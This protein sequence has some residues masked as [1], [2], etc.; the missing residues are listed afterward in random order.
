M[1][2]LCFAL[3]HC[4]YGRYAEPNPPV[5]PP[6]VY[7]FEPGD[8]ATQSIIDKIFAENGGTNPTWNGQFSD[9]R[10][11][12]LFKPGQ[13]G[14]DVNVGYYT[15]VIGL[16]LRPTDVSIPNVMAS[17]GDSNY[18]GGALDNF[19]RSAEN[20]VTT[21]TKTQ[22]GKNNTM[23]WAVSQGVSL[24]RIIVNGNLDL[25]EGQGYASGGYMSNSYVFGTIDSGSQQQWYTRNAYMQSW[26]GAHWNFLYQGDSFVNAPNSVC[27]NKTSLSMVIDSTPV[28]AEKPFIT[29]DWGA[30]RYF[31]AI[32][33]IEFN[34]VGP[35]DY[36]ASLNKIPRV[37]F[38]NVYVTNPATD[39]AAS[40]NAKIASGLHIIFTPGNYNLTEAIQVTQSNVCLV[41]IGYPTLMPMNGNPAI[42][43]SDGVVGVRISSVLLQAGP[44]NSSTLLQFGST[45]GGSSNGYNFLY[46]IFGRVGGP[47]DPNV[48]QY[49]TDTMVQ[50]N[51]DNVVM[52]N[53]WL[54]RADHDITGGYVYSGDNPVRTALQVYG[55]NVVLYALK[56]EHTLGNI[57][58]WYGNNGTCF[59]FQSEFPYDVTQ[60]EYGDPGFNAFRVDES[61]TLFQGYSLGMYSFFRDYAVTVENAMKAPLNVA[62]VNVSHAFT[63]WLNGQG[64]ISHVI[65]D[66][67]VAVNSQF[68]DTPSAVCK[69]NQ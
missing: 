56:A 53:S 4:V 25:Y 63:I 22:N 12:L 62:G 20:F 31:L 57:V 26:Q 42:E 1:L 66:M 11:A 33:P 24:R 44:Q 55:D 36:N 51:M 2:Y 58:E 43:V 40:I 6:S 16:G 67:G 7:V 54:W 52:D 49:M 34:K 15:S 8:D 68:A 30:N 39:T 61:V 27:A 47:N 38:N 21:P 46:D 13:Y 48:Q 29:F 69:L 10:Y 9:S 17:N 5:W 59:F 37:D 19:W 18:T 3:L 60:S 14:V 45:K 65:D 35:T 50:I 32:P 41:G 64:E 28:I 23:L